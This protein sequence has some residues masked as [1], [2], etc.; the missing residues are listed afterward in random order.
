MGRGAG[1][2]VAP[3][4]TTAKKRGSLTYSCSFGKAEWWY[5]PFKPKIPVVPLFD[6]HL[7]HGLLLNFL[8]HL[9]LLNLF[10]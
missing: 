6:L 7:D 3:I 9:H 10:K 8:L 1:E 5:S 4:Q 2:G